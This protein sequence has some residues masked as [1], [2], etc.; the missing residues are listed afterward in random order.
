MPRSRRTPRFW[1]VF[2]TREAGLRF[3]GGLVSWRG[4][5]IGIWPFQRGR[6]VDDAQPKPISEPKASLVTT[7][8]TNAAIIHK[9]PTTSP[10]SDRRDFEK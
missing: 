10:P 4:K 8:A 5:G 2:V 7:S 6:R 9:T 3:S 1:R